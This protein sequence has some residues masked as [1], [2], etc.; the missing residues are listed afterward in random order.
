MINYRSITASVCFCVLGWMN[1]FS[2]EKPDVWTPF[3]SDGP[4]KVFYKYAVCDP[5]IGYDNESVLLKIINV[6]NQGVIASW[7]REIY[8]DGVCTTCDLG[9]EGRS[10]YKLAPNEVAEGICSVSGDRRLKLFCEF[11]DPQ[12][13]LKQPLFTGF[14]LNNFNIRVE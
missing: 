1:G 4:V 2:Q 3:L 12:Y 8:F 6:S 5:E 10:E 11:T 9:D 14:K 7:D 13:K